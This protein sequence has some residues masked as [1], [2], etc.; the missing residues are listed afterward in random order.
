MWNYLYPYFMKNTG[1]GVLPP[2]T[3]YLE[4]SAPALYLLPFLVEIGYLV[5]S[6]YRYSSVYGIC[7]YYEINSVKFMS[8]QPKYEPPAKPALAT[9]K[10]GEHPVSG[11]ENS[12]N[13]RAGASNQT[14]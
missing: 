11:R 13:R 2:F 12:R 5:R 7:Y 4:T 9:G 10:A 3:E 1:E 8:W 6:P 14:L